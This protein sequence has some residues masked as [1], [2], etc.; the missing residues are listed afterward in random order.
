ML[1]SA[2]ASNCAGVTPGRT[3]SRRTSS[4]RPT[5]RP[6]VRIFSICGG[7]LI[8]MPRPRRLI[9]VSALVDLVEGLDDALGHVGDLA[10]AVD[11]DQQ[12]TLAVDLDQRC[13]LFAVDLLAV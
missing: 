7:V 6:A 2:S 13:G 8:W 1:R 4:V 9:A 5:S 11:L 12:P 3:A 10:H